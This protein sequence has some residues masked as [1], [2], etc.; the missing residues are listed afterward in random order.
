MKRKH[1]L[2]IFLLITIILCLYFYISSMYSDN[3]DNSKEY[4]EEVW[5]L[6]IPE[7]Y[8]VEEI[9]TSK[10][11]WMGDGCRIFS[12]TSSKINDDEFN[13]K[14]N[15]PLEEYLVKRVYDSV[16]EDA[17]RVSNLSAPSFSDLKIINLLV[18]KEK[19]DYLLITFSKKDNR[20]YIF[21]DIT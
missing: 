10:D 11:R 5:K 17:L 20:Y 6:K 19:D 16:A 21:E 13:W 3:S 2:V 14:A 9:Y 1:L 7:K 12:I 15:K 18:S 8:M 4:L